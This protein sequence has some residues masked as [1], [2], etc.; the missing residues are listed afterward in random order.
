M[1]GEAMGFWLALM[2][3]DVLTRSIIIAGWCSSWECGAKVPVNDVCKRFP[4]PTWL[5]IKVALL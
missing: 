4:C 5:T 3:K 2:T 1:F